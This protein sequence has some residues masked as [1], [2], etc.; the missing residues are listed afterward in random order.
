[1]AN[2]SSY[3]M[4]VPHAYKAGE[5]N[6]TIRHPS[7]NGKVCHSICYGDFVNIYCWFSESGTR[8]E[9]TGPLQKPVIDYDLSRRYT[10]TWAAMEKLVES[11][12]ARSIGKTYS[13]RHIPSPLTLRL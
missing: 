13:P 8:A 10:D 6:K 3:T 7:G 4:T 1:M 12:K 9:L 11:G 5:N 2:G